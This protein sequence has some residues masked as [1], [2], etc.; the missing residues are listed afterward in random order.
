MRLLRS[1]SCLFVTIMRSDV[2]SASDRTSQTKQSAS[3]IKIKN[4]NVRRYSYKQS[5]LIIVRFLIKIEIY[6][7]G[8]VK[9]PN[10]EFH[11]NPSNGSRAV[12]YQQKE[13]RTDMASRS[14]LR[15]RLIKSVLKKLATIY[16][17]LS[18]PQNM[19]YLWGCEHRNE[20]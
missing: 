12:P 6:L 2:S 20:I 4:I 1:L 7:R 19:V 5:V 15:E 9:I 8:L 13:E 18:I 3:C 17:L 14:C 16:D 10:I 11:G